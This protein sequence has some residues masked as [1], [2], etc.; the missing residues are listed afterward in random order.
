MF[1]SV[2]RTAY[3]ILS[4]LWRQPR[5]SHQLLQQLPY[6]MRGLQYGGAWRRASSPE[7]NAATIPANPLQTYFEGHTTGHGIWKWEHYLEIYHR[8]LNRFCGREVHILEIG[9]YSGGSLEM[10]REY[11]GPDCYVYGVDIEEACRVYEDARTKILIGDQGDRVF[12]QFVREQVPRIDILIDDGGHRTEQQIATLE[13]M[14]PH[15]QP[16]GVY[17]CEDILG[18]PLNQFNAY[19]SGLMA[20]FNQ[21]NFGLLADTSQGVVWPAT[22][23][24]TEIEAAHFYPYVTVIEKRARPALKLAAPKKGTQWQPFL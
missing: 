23:W 14:L 3:N 13:E 1:L 11:F 15:L 24:Q 18:S 20:Q 10:W 17:L 2:A 6:T 19:V 9:I 4:G 21:F 8:H 22:P 12:W 5:L 16:G 7:F